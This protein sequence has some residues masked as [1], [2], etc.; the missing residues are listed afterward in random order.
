MHLMD[1]CDDFY[2]R[3]I[4]LYSETFDEHSWAGFGIS[5]SP[6]RFYSRKSLSKSPI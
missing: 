6:C 1:L 5:C 4:C 3:N 2:S